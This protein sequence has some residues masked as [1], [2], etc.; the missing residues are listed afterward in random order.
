MNISIFFISSFL[1]FIG[2]HILNYSA[3]M[4]SLDV[5]N[6]SLIAGIAF[7]FCFGTSL[8]FGWFAGAAIDRYS[9]K[10]ILLI[11]QLIHVIGAIGLWFVAQQP[12]QSD[13]QLYSL[14]ASCF[15]IGI[16]WSF[17]AP[18]RM[19]QMAQYLSIERLPQGAII[20]N[21][22]LM[23]GFGLAPVLI[24]QLKEFADWNNVIELS[25]LLIFSSALL[26]LNA[27]NVFV[28]KEHK[29]LLH[30][31]QECF[32]QLSV[33][34]TSAQFLL[35][36][37][38]GFIIVGPMQ[39]VLPVIA[40]N[41]LV[42]DSAQVGQYMG[43][44]A[45]GLICGGIAAMKLKA[46]LHIGRFIIA[47]LLFSSFGMMLVGQI[48]DI[49]WNSAF[50]LITIIMAGIASSFI[51]AGVQQQTPVDIKGRVMSMY[52]ITSQ[53]MPAISGAIAGALSNQLE[54][55]NSLLIMGGIMMLATIILAIQSRNLR[56]FSS[57]Q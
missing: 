3:I 33:H 21:L 34:K 12:A 1:A 7:S 8:L 56:S 6:S 22:L 14:F 29:H 38:V 18:A 16:G 35:A 51:I 23:I 43:L 41:N 24:T 30:E 27:P 48:Q 15:I 9:A 17:I 44:V 55:S 42:L 36:A 25:L 49:V 31:W 40:E 26:M 4:F 32:Q 57:F 39:V 50:L 47:A 20:Y 2:G 53:A 19:T 11:S 10:R 37:L 46:L 45:V 5:F 28:H 54:A 13:T 52:T